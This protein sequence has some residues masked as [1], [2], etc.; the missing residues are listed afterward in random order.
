MSATTFVLLSLLYDFKSY[1]QNFKPY[2]A[3]YAPGNYSKSTIRAAV[4][5][6]LESGDIEKIVLNGTAHFSLTVKGFKTITYR[7]S[8]Q[9]NA[10]R[11]HWD[12]KWRIIIF[13]IPES[14]RKKRAKVRKILT[15]FNFGR[16]SNSIYISPFDNLKLVEEK[17]KDL[18]RNIRVFVFEASAI[19]NEKETA[20]IAFN[21]KELSGKYKSWLRKVKDPGQEI[22][23]LVSYYD[24]VLRS[25]PALP[26]DLL[27]DNWPFIKTWSIFIGLIR[28]KASVGGV[29]EAKKIGI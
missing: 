24:R 13:D 18:G 6:L 1:R 21:L 28:K 5:H 22:D 17:I 4:N 12:R 29:V 23:I 20:L 19:G 27:P 15:K 10:L 25:D 16:L 9:Y 11:T 8:R 14:Q 26:L 3:I 7:F 2:S